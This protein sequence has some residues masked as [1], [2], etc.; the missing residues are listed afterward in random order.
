MVRC[1][2]ETAFGKYVKSIV[3][4]V[5]AFLIF[6]SNRAK[7]SNASYYNVSAIIEEC[8]V[9]AS[10]LLLSDTMGNYKTNIED[11]IEMLKY[12]NKTV[13]CGFEKDILLELK[14]TLVLINTDSYDKVGDKLKSVKKLVELRLMQTKKQGRF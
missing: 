1:D 10:E 3:A 14:E 6:F 11:I 5:D 2:L 9:K 4:V 7:E 8:V 13:M 12:S